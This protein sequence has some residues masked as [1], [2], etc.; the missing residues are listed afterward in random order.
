MNILNILQKLGV[1]TKKYPT[2]RSYLVN[3]SEISFLS[4][5]ICYIEEA[6]E[7]ALKINELTEILEEFIWNNFPD[8]KFDYHENTEKGCYFLSIL[9]SLVSPWNLVQG[10]RIN[11]LGEEYYHSWCEKDS[12]VYDPSMRVITTKEKYEKFFISENVYKKEEIK[13]LFLQTGTF[14]H[15]KYDLIEGKINP[16]YH[17]LY[18]K[19][20]IAKITALD[21]LEKLDKQVGLK[22]DSFEK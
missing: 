16:F 15:F 11:E 4:S 17:S 18:Y 9:F 22:E 20:E 8:V 12:L 6:K 14:T 3:K 19:T 21:I 7:E 2:L 10:K 5:N 13:E 1:D